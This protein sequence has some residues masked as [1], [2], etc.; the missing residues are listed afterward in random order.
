MAYHYFGDV[1]TFDTTYRTNKYEMPFAPFTGVNHHL[2]SIQFGCALLQDEAEVTFLWLFETWLEAMGGRAPTSI[3]TDQDLAMKGAIAKVFPNTRHRLCI[4]HIKKKF[5]EKLSQ[6]YYKRSKFKAE[7]KKCIWK[8][9]KK[10]D[11]EERW[12]AL[13]KEYGLETNE[14]L[15]QLYDI[16]ESWV[17]VYNRG[18]FFAGMNTTGR[19]EG[20]NSFFDGFVTS[21]TNLKEFVVKYEQAL[22]KIVKR[23]SDEDFES[24]HKFRIVNE[25]EFLLKHA[26]KIYTR[27]VFNK[28]KDEISEVFRYK[29]ED[30]GDTNRFQSFVVKSKVYEFEKFIV[31]LDLQTYEGRC[32]CQNF[33]FVGILCTH[34]LKVFIRLDIDAIPDHF[35]LPRWRQ[36]ANKFR[37]IDTEELVHD[38]GKEESEALRLSHMCQESTKLACLAAPSNEAYTIYIETMNG[39][40][41]KLIKVTS[42]VPSMDVCLEKDNVHTTEP[43]Q[44]LIFDPN[45]SQTKGRKKDAMGKGASIQFGRLKSGLEMALNKKKRKCNLCNK[46][47]HDKRTCPENPMSKTYKD[48]PIVHD[49]EIGGDESQKTRCQ[50]V[51]VASDDDDGDSIELQL[52]VTATGGLQS[53]VKTIDWAGGLQSTTTATGWVQSTT[54]TTGPFNRQ[55][56]GGSMMV[57]GACFAFESLDRSVSVV[58]AT[59]PSIGRS[60]SVVVATGP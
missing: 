27:N 55:F 34:M 12:M 48:I 49:N 18:T 46:F 4:W 15:Q 36:K 8:T 40:F 14:W 3:I 10:E 11:F 53:T 31:T 20:V 58:V 60:M 25:G 17:P 39:L 1:V 19:S 7:V 41:E 24:E 6:V 44:I 47:G 35:I 21:T 29:V 45:I 5:V 33:E 26:A 56:G 50:N 2:H 38:D 57:G 23:E 22:K 16:R 13:I 42:Y 9:Y 37:I 59:G 43:S 54:T 28:F 52:T 32:E 30:V 51:D